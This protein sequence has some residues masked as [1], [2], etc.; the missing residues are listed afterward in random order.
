MTDTQTPHQNN[1]PYYVLRP[2]SAAFALN[3][4]IITD[5]CQSC[6]R[7]ML[8]KA[9]INKPEY[10]DPKYQIMG[11]AGED[12]YQEELN[13]IGGLLAHK[14]YKVTDYF[15]GVKRNGRIDFLVQHPDFRVIHECKTTQSKYVYNDVFIK[16]S[17]KVSHLAQ[18]VF[19]LIMLEETRGKLIYRYY[20]T[21]ET[22][23]FKVEVGKGGKLLI[24]N[25][26][27]EFSIENQISH[28]L[29]CVDAIK[30]QDLP[31]SIPNKSCK[32]CLYKKEC[33][34]FDDSCLSFKDFSKIKEQEW[35]QQ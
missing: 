5:N 34:E 27:C 29:I 30:N 26:K 25:N 10:V 3:G 32:F 7:N 22:K 20:P 14:E 31:A 13:K 4:E 35:K 2:S 19:Y 21:Q 33:K 6:P 8:F 1:E 16:G 24:N 9:I 28:Q 17:P 18:V 15:E 12:L 23:I 11:A